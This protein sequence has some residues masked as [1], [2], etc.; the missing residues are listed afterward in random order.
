MAS[1]SYQ[2]RVA[3]GNINSWNRSSYHSIYEAYDRPSSNKI[4]AWQYCIDLCNK[5]N[6]RGLKVISRNTYTFTA[7]FEFDDAATGEVMF[8]F[9][10]PSYDVAVSI[11]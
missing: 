8:M 1:L 7:G 11:A 5:N 6:G 9:I 2:K 3:K 10:T 4:S